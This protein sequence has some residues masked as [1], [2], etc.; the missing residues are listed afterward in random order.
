MAE[1]YPSGHRIWRAPIAHFSP[2][3]LNFP[4]S[5]PDDAIY[6]P[7]PLVKTNDG[8]READKHDDDGTNDDESHK[9]P[10]PATPAPTC[11]AGSVIE[12]ENQI[13]RQELPIIGTPY[14]LAYSTQRTPG[15]AADIT[16]EIQLTGNT[17]PDSLG[18]IEAKVSGHGYLHEER[19]SRS[20][21]TA[22]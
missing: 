20:Q 5:P 10:E 3:D 4:W 6:P 8:P 22:E 9:K 14:P 15:W 1:L 11:A 13:V 18:W 12:C 16:A 17:V 21:V 2:A 7:P 19:F